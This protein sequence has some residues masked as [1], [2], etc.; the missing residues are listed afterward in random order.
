[1]KKLRANK[2]GNF[3]AKCGSRLDE[4]TGLCPECDKSRLKK[5]NRKRKLRHIITVFLL[6]VG[7]I[8]VV[9]I[10][11]DHFKVTDITLTNIISDQQKISYDN[12]AEDINKEI[13]PTDTEGIIYYQTSDDS[14]EQDNDTGILYVNNEVL[15]ML[16]NDFSKE[17]FTKYL[18][19]L[20]GKI[21]GELSDI[22]EYQIQLERSLTYSELSSLVNDLQNRDEVLYASPNYAFQISENYYPDDSRWKNEWSNIP[23]GENWGMEAID[24]PGAWEYRNQMQPVNVG[25]LD[26]MF[27]VNHKDLN[28]VEQPLGNVAATSGEWDNHGTHVAGTI[29][30]TFDNGT[31]VTG[32]LP[33]VNLYGVSARGLEKNKYSYVQSLEMAF[34]YL[35]VK[36]N[37]SVINFSMSVDTLTFCAAKD[38]KYNEEL[39][40]IAGDIS[41]FFKL[42]INNDYSFVIC[43]AA[44]NQNEV[45]GGYRYFKK[46]EE[47][48]SKYPY[49]YYRYEDYKKYLKGDKT[50][51]EYFAFYK[52]KQKEIEKRL[53]SGNVDAKYDILGAIDDVEV[54]KRI[55]MVGSAENLTHKE[56]GLLGIGSKTIHDGYKI[57]V[58]SQCGECVSVIAPG[59]NIYST[60]KNSYGVMSG[61]SMACPHVSGIA[62]LIFSV[63]PDID[64]DLVK[65]IIRESA[66]GK[67]GE[68]GY[69]MA[70]AKNAVEMA[71]EYKNKKKT[72]EQLPRTTALS[73][74]RNI[75][76]T[77]DTSGSMDGTPIQE[78][79]KAANKFVDTVLEEDASIGIVTYESSAHCISEFS[80]N[81]SV[82]KN[83]LSEVYALGGT[84][85]D[86]G[87][88]QACEMLSSGNARKKMIIL[89]TD[90]EPNEGRCGDDLIAY[91]DEI[92]KTGILIYTIGFFENSD[93]TKSY[94]QA[95]MEAIASE[96][97]HYEVAS[98]DDLIFFFKDIADQMNGQKY[99]YVRIACPVDVSVSYQG[100]TLT[101]SEDALN[102]RTD[103]GTLSFE[104]VQDS[105]GNVSE[106][107]VK[108][109]RLKEGVDYDV[110]ITGTGRGLMDYT[111]G[112]MD[113]DGNYSDFRK[114]EHVKITGKT[115]IDT[116]AA[117]SEVSVLNIDE[118]GDGKYDVKLQAGKN[119]YGEEIHSNIIIYAGIAAGA[120]I[121]LVVSGVVILHA[122]KRKKVQ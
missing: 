29:A 32:V 7:I 5:A 75:V 52:D 19:P 15:V 17:E 3:C 69:G 119:G 114:F 118:D 99:I 78:T 109:L 8:G 18:A 4:K 96:G 121:I 70:N 11:L 20:G 23:G 34:Y 68:Y 83:A 50:N 97:C 87:L 62:G 53:E 54:Q 66:V 74:E 93:G 117:V 101:S 61:T 115:K 85:I 13:P 56:G 73:N 111:I 36:K 84:N 49:L 27:D 1:M 30:A 91:A 122:R 80:G 112:F 82:L 55:I 2:K 63:N 67:Y 88:Q 46:D 65:E 108:I 120:G 41:E 79:V 58:D 22:N 72:D 89:M 25:I 31:G 43:K 102:L 60:I 94:E 103:F 95:L 110:K 14:V 45:N 64:S 92:K 90:G 9:I 26:L 59:V 47:D 98:A 71:L 21:V 116:V 105:E 44:G 12:E 39:K 104:D 35:V 86:E 38:D 48:H 106:D 10:G 57:A 51:E 107:Q 24:V 16:E 113:D 77:L 40:K 33:K 76:L 6:I 28:F 42:L 37:C 100:Q 81:K